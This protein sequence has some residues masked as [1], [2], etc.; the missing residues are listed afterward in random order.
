MYGGWMGCCECV[1]VCLCTY[2]SANDNDMC[3]NKG[4]IY[5]LFIIAVR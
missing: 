5:L 2:I 1:S 3:K 4:N